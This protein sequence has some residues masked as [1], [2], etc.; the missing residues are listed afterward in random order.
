MTLTKP[1]RHYPV[2]DVIGINQRYQRVHIKQSRQT[3]NPSLFKIFNFLHSDRA[4]AW[5][6]RKGGYNACAA[7][8][9]RGWL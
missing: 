3:L 7:V 5:H 2:T 9:T 6:A 1:V 8:R 4:C